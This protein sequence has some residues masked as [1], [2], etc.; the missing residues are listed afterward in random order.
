M[1][2]IIKMLACFA[3]LVTMTNVVD[4]ASTTV[5]NNIKKM[6]NHQQYKYDHYQ[7]INHDAN[8][9]VHEAKANIESQ[10]KII[11]VEEAKVNKLIDNLSKAEQRLAHVK[12]QLAY[13]KNRVRVALNSK[14][15]VPVNVINE[16]QYLITALTN[17]YRNMCLIRNNDDPAQSP[18]AQVFYP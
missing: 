12:K 18:L 4:A 8:I 7:Q 14:E 2:H 10:R 9:N 11:V 1:K 5:C 6:I 3:I 17:K 13:E 15:T 16:E